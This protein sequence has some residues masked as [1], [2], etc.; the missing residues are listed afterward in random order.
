[1][2]ELTAVALGRKGGKARLKT[3]TPE[4]R[5]EIARMG[6]AATNAKLHGTPIPVVQPARW[7]GLV[8]LPAG[9]QWR[10]VAAATDELHSNP[11]VILWSRDR[12]EV[13]ERLQQA[14]MRDRITDIIDVDFDPTRFTIQREYARDVG[15]QLKGLR[16]VLDT[17]GGQS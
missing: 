1:M 11:E 15:R 2:S 8:A 4:R 14:D 16:A 12:A 17:E 5:R 13:V 10:G 7:Y 9:Y 6:A 3:M